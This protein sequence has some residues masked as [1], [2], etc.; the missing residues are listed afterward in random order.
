M[1]VLAF[2]CWFCGHLH[3]PAMHLGAF[4]TLGSQTLQNAPEGIW[5]PGFSETMG[6][7]TSV[8]AC[9]HMRV[10]GK[11]GRSRCFHELLK[12]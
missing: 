3:P 2:P 1:G 10:L 5:G 6:Q 11:E 9:A 4:L 12:S 8:C 7:N